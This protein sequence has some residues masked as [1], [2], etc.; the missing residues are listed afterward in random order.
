MGFYHSGSAKVF[1]SFDLILFILTLQNFREGS[2]PVLEIRQD[3]L[4]HH[5]AFKIKST[6]EPKFFLILLVDTLLIALGK[7]SFWTTVYLLDDSGSYS[8][9][10]HHTKKPL[11]FSQFLSR[12]VKVHQTEE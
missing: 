7:V 11:N 5:L 4:G 8:K 1:G 6:I 3:I 10:K 2:F 9:K 12:Y